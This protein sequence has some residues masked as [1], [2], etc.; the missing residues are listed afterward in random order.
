MLKC[1]FVAVVTVLMTA[2]SNKEGEDDDRLDEMN[3]SCLD[4]GIKHRASLKT[5]QKKT[6]TPHA[7]LILT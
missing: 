2:P 7:T 4:N 5:K 6:T 3:C 1:F